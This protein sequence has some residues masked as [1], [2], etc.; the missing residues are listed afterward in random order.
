MHPEH[1]EVLDAAGLATALDW[2]AAEGWNPGVDDGPAFLAADPEGFLGAHVDG[3]LAVTVSLVRYDD[4]FAF[5]GFS[6]AAP[7]HRGRG[8]ARGLSRV[9]LERAAGRVVGLDAVLEQEATYA[10]DGFVTAHG[11]TRYTWTPTT[12]GPPVD[13]PVDA[14]SVGVGILAEYERALFPAPRARF[15]D[16]WLAM[17][18][19]VSLAVVQDGVLVG[20]GL[21]R[22]CRS[23]HKIG[24]LFA[25]S[26]EV[27][28]VLL[29]ALV[30]DADGPVSL[31]VPDP[32]LGARSLVDRHGMTPV[33]STRRMYRGPAPVLDLER[34]Y[35]VT[36]L[37]LG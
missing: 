18:S 23:G 21:R 31:D 30:R 3:E 25:D 27:A 2:A 37:E 20:W 4:R 5:G 11:T 22:R 15:L 19:A 28:D 10:R 24:P 34:V 7:D 32:N 35:G 8:I 1:I 29:R 17:P 9:V 36:T 16:A 6:I 26:P 33:F 13:P 14:R 12:A